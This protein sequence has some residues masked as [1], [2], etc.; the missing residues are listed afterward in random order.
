MGEELAKMSTLLLFWSLVQS[1]SGGRL[2]QIACLLPWFPQI[3]PRTVRTELCQ[4]YCSRGTVD[5]VLQQ[6]VH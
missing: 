4:V 1:T 2:E 6:E 5:R 3:S